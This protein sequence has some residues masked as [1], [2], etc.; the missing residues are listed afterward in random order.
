[1]QWKTL[2]DLCVSDHYP[3]TV[4]LGT[5]EIS[6]AISS[7][8]LCKGD[9]VSFSDKAKEQL[10]TDNSI[11]EFSEKSI[12]VATDAIQKNKFSHQMRNSLI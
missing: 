11:Y 4:C 8:K 12:A 6:S 2:D 7:W 3:I 1:M 5:S 9:W 10:G